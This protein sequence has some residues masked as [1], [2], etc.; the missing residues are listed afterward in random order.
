MYLGGMYNSIKCSVCDNIINLFKYKSMKDW[1]INGYLCSNCYSKKI[2][3]HYVHK[4]EDTL[5]N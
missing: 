5:K 3:E 1:Q 2:K 4:K